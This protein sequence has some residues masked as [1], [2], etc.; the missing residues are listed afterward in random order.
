MLGPLH[1]LQKLVPHA[2]V[3][4]GSLYQAG[5]ISNGNL[6]KTHTQDNLFISVEMFR[7]KDPPARLSILACNPCTTLCRS[8]VSK[9]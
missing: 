7:L 4:V 2:F 9:L 1:V 6:P 5:E 8:L 3:Q